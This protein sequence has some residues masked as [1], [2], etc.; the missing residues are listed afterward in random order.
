[1]GWPHATCVNGATSA[2]KFSLILYGHFKFV[3]S[4]RSPHNI[5]LTTFKI[6]QS[7]VITIVP[8]IGPPIVVPVGRAI[9]NKGVDLDSRF[10][11]NQNSK[12]QNHILSFTGTI[13]FSWQC[14]SRSYTSFVFKEVGCFFRGWGEKNISKRHHY[15]CR[16]LSGWCS[17]L[18][19]R[20][21]SKV[22][23]VTDS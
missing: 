18:L 7:T 10:Q 2:N 6:F 14:E 1:M 5:V 17:C 16:R 23:P 12:R 21:R 22:G 9:Q 3:Y 19:G 8:P 20:H 15:S 11:V 13:V 4:C